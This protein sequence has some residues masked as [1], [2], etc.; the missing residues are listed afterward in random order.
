[1][2]AAGYDAD[3]TMV[4]EVCEADP[5]ESINGIAGGDARRRRLLNSHGCTNYTVENNIVA[6]LGVEVTQK[7][8]HNNCARVRI[9]AAVVVHLG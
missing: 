2:F 5:D 3:A 6:S 8:D 4:A 9:K 1:M 7:R